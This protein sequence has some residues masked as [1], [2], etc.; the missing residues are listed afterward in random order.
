MIVTLPLDAAGADLDTVGGKGASLATLARAGLPVPPGIHITTDAYRVFV[1]SGLDD[2]LRDAL[3]RDNAAERIAALFAAQDI[4]PSVAQAIR[5]AVPTG[6]VAV[7]SSATAEDLPELSFAGQH[8]SFLNVCGAEA[9]LDAVKRCWASLWTE[10]AIGYRAH[11]GIDAEDVAIAVVVQELVPADAAGVLF[12]ANPLT[13]ARDEQVVNAAWGLGEAVVGGQVTPDTYVVGDGH[14]ISREI[15]DKTVMTVGTDTGTGER[16]VPDDRRRTPVLDDTQAV[17]LAV[18]GA[19]IEELYGTPMDVEWALRD[20]R[21]SILQARPIT[22]LRPAGVEWND[23]LGGDYLWTCVNLGEAV[24][25]VMTPATWS[26]VKI[27]SS[28]AVGPYRITGNIGGRFYL[29]LSVSTAAAAAVGMGAAVRK[30]SEQTLGRIP[31]D[32]EIPPLPM[33]RLAVIRAAIPFAKEAVAYRRKLPQLVADTPIRCRDLREDIAAAADPRALAELWRS[34][35]DSLLH[36]T[37]RVLDTGARGAGPVKLERALRDLVGDAD[38]TTLMTGLHADGDELASLG[39]LLGLARL[40]AGKLDRAGYAATWGHRCPDEF[41]I[42]EPRPAEDPAWIDRLID[43]VGELDP[44][45]LLDRQAAARDAAWQRLVE[46]HP[47]KAKRVRRQLDR[48]AEVARARERARSEMVRAFWVLRAFVLRAGDLTGHG[49]DLFFLPIDQI[50]AV[51]DGDESPLAT[52]PAQRAAYD[53]YRALPPYPTLIRGRFDPEAWAADPDRR[54][55]L[56]DA[57]ADHKPLGEAIT[58]FPGAVGVVDGTARV[59]STV[60]EAAA[61]RPGEILVTTVTNVGWTPLF[62]RA[63]A[64]VTDV[65]APLSHAAIVARELGIPAVVG[66]GNATTRLSTGDRVRVDGAKGTVTLV[67]DD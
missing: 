47:G 17:E 11:H 45:A 61:L 29:N 16:P 44:R 41:E 19:R 62:P 38:A 66:C 43:T 54:S 57:T 5:D 53:R 28:A 8:D 21:F 15:A 10:R 36:E 12:T 22:T 48:A 51:L 33:S 31:E 1:A 4:P 65:G 58:G 40:R 67:V 25:S 7:R 6:P 42:A 26:L 34:D 52:V 64:I 56:F 23:T 60:D 46:R 2:D 3:T 24:P 63:A 37:C 35:L 13:G 14:V 50:V 30:Q 39:P 9:V 59:V 55:D 20:G 49:A 27:L 18:L 32:V